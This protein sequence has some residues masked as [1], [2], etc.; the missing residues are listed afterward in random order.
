[1]N[2]LNAAIEEGI[3]RAVV[4]SSI[5]TVYDDK[6]DKNK[7]LSES[8]WGDVN[9]V[10]LQFNKSY[11]KSK[12]YAEKAAWD[13]YEK[14][15]KDGFK[16]ATILPTFTIGPVLSSFNKSSVGLICSSFD[17]TIPHLFN[18]MQ[19]LCDVRDVALAHLKAAQLDEAVGQRFIITTTDRFLP[20]SDIFRIIEQFGYELNKNYTEPLDK[21]EYKNT[22]IDNSKMRKFLKIEP[23]DIKK[24]TLDMVQS[25]FEYGILK[26]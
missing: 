7:T 6:S 2:V 8:D 5:V 15:K 13:F 21:D 3:K 10:T 9:N 20:I 4:T 11:Q 26:K 12:I 17:K 24:T 1:M 16:L 18:L 14:H 19:P 22:L 23:I 25:F